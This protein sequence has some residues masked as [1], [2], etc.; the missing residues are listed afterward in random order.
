MK[1]RLVKAGYENGKV[2]PAEQITL[3]EDYGMITIF[4]PDCKKCKNC[5]DCS[6]DIK[7]FAVPDD[8][9]GTLTIDEVNELKKK[10]LDA[11]KYRQQLKNPPIDIEQVVE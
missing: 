9:N 8:I 1:Y 3:P 2:R 7:Y 6:P 11:F 10:G 5:T 4:N